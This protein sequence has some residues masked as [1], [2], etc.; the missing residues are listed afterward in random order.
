MLASADDS[1]SVINHKSVVFVHCCCESGNLLS[2]LVSDGCV[3]MVDIIAESDFTN[4]S[5]VDRV[6]KSIR[7]SADVFSIVPHAQE[8]HHGRS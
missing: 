3:T 6:I 8:G 2:R 5:T 1:S 4:E 7:T